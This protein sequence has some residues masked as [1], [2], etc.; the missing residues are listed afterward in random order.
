MN[1]AVRISTSLLLSL[2]LLV[3]GSGLIIGKMVCLKSGYTQITTNEAKDCCLHEEGKA[4]FEDQ[5]CAV[6]NISFQQQHFVS[7]NQQVIKSFA[8]PAFISFPAFLAFTPADLHLNSQKFFIAD[9]PD[10]VS[11]SPALPLLCVFRV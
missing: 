7:Q 6:N 10:L 9:P 5:C 4:S 1:K 11:G 3:S 8:A 2:L